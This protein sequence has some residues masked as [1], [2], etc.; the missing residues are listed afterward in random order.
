MSRRS[1]SSS[2]TSREVGKSKTS[3]APVRA[4]A[5]CQDLRRYDVAE[6]EIVPD[7]KP[8]WSDRDLNAPPQPVRL[9]R[10]L[11]TPGGV[12]SILFCQDQGEVQP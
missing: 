6:A 1:A 2:A 12:P 10:N 5:Y 11:H 8:F 9:H 4:C 7:Y 3:A